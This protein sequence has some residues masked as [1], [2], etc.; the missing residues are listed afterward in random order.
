MLNAKPEPSLKDARAAYWARHEKPLKRLPEPDPKSFRG[1]IL[2]AA[3]KFR[4]L[5]RFRV[6]DLLGTIRALPGPRVL[7]QRPD[8]EFT[9]P[10]LR[11]VLFRLA[12]DGHICKQPE[13]GLYSSG[14]SN[15]YAADPSDLPRPRKRPKPT[16]LH[17]RVLR[18]VE[19]LAGTATST[20]DIAEEAD[21][22]S[23]RT[24]AACSQLA[25]AGWIKRKKRGHYAALE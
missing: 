18:A 19:R 3:R 13:R 12:A 23:S 5:Q 14:E 15:R 16:S 4:P 17:G 24:A 6:R 25:A 22:G 10:E 20:H 7:G 1:Q 11:V 9:E 8:R 21:A 2:A